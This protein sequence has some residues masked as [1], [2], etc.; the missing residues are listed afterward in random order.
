MDV[1]W[2]RNDLQPDAPLKSTM[3]LSVK[4][5]RESSGKRS[6]DSQPRQGVHTSLT[7]PSDSKKSRGCPLPGNRNKKKPASALPPGRP[8]L[9]RRVGGIAPNGNPQCWYAPHESEVDPHRIAQR[10]K[11]VEFGKNSAGYKAYVDTV[12]R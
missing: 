1:G 2:R 9:A 5:E 11:Q 3:H 6:R 10:M 8:H 4:T 7:G 12:P